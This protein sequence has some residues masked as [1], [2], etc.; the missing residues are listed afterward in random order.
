MDLW[1]TIGIV[2]FAVTI[3]ALLLVCNGLNWND[4][5]RQAEAEGLSDVGGQGHQLNGTARP[6]LD[7]SVSA[8][9]DDRYR[10]TLGTDG[11]G[12]GQA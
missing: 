3:L 9:D 7:D 2:W 6:W 10:T 12:S 5:E 11:G 8:Q 4:D 1:I